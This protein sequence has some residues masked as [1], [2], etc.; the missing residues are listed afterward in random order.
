MRAAPKHLIG[1]LVHDYALGKN[2]IVVSGPFTE[3]S[4]DNDITPGRPLEWE[5]LVLY[6]DGELM[7]GDTNDLK[8]INESR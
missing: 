8:V 2:G 4:S 5:W 6:E 3:E 7:G 1:K